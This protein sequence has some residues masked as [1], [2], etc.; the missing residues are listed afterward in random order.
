MNIRFTGM[1]EKIIDGVIADIKDH[2]ELSSAWNAA[3][4]VTRKAIRERWL[5]ICTEQLKQF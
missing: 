2:K 4:D 3:D 1:A 5:T